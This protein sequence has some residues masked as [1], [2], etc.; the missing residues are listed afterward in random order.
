MKARDLMTS[1]PACCT[2][3]DTVEKAAQLMTDNDCGC[4]PVVENLETKKIVGTVTDRDIACRCIGE[5]KGPETT[6]REAMSP[7]PSCCRPEDDLR[8]VERIM[9]ER[10]VR[11]VPVV[12][13]NGCCVGMIAQS[14]L[15]REE[16]RRAAGV[17]Q[18][19]SQPTSTPRTDADAGRRPE[20]R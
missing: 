6:V 20:G 11:R 17:V 19:V 12:D 7:D 2:P 14:D 9:A 10:Q 8:E 3:N 16:K 4:L 5:G 1:D 18:D 15:A 13:D